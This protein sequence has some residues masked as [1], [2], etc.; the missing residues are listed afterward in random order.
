MLFQSRKQA[1]QCLARRLFSYH[2][3]DTVVVALPLGGIPVAAEVAKI[4]NCEL[5]V[6]N[7]RKIGTPFQSELSV[8][9]VSEDE[10]V[11]WNRRLLNLIGFEPSDLNHLVENE[12]KKIRY[13]AEVFRQGSRFPIIRNRTVLIVDDGMITGSTMFSA[14]KYLK[15]QNPRR[16][17]V[18]VPAGNPQTVLDLRKDVDEF[19]VLKEHESHLKLKSIY[20]DFSRLSVQEAYSILKS[21]VNYRSTVLEDMEFDKDTSTFVYPLQYFDH[22]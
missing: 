10:Q 7:V 15:S 13:Y 19:V 5:S 11:S 9:A 1:G 20:N 6:L 12:I 2:Q 14:I 21:S 16:L 17:E 22:G 4:L 8:G 3:K 18:A